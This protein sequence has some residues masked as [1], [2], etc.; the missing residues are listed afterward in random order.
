MA[1]FKSQEIF[2]SA[3]CMWKGQIEYSWT[4][5]DFA[6]LH[7]KSL[8]PHFSAYCL[9]PCLNPAVQ[10]WQVAC[11]CD[12]FSSYLGTEPKTCV[13]LFFLLCICPF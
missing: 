3:V 2:D 1:F 9:I 7:L 6:L 8:T 4:K 5:E 11:G 12:R 10:L 13:T